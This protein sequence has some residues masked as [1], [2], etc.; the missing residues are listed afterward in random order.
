ML[1]IHFATWWIYENGI[2]KE[3]SA[4]CCLSSGLYFSNFY[5]RAHIHIHKKAIFAINML[6]SY[7]ITKEKSL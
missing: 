2:N 4:M 1:T 6:E 5:V 3:I 7:F